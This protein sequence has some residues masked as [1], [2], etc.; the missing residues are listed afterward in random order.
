MGLGRHLIIEMYDCDPL[1][2]DNIDFI[3]QILIEAAKATKSTILWYKFH[4]FQPQGVTGIVIV[5][6]SHLSIHTWPEFGYAAIDVFTCG[7]H[8]DPWKALD[9]LKEAFKPKRMSVLEI[10]RGIITSISEVR[11]DMVSHV[12]KELIGIRE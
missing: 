2:L 3:E 9:V 7:T 10:K 4:K 8:T 6:E 1:L 12:S 11:E 5:A